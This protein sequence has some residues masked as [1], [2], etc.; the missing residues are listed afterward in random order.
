MRYDTR[1]GKGPAAIAAAPHDQIDCA[2]IARRIPAR[3]V[4]DEHCA[5]RCHHDSRNAVRE[6]STLSRLENRSLREVR[7]REGELREKQ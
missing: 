2:P 6:I 7:G 3:F 5:A 4:V 1:R